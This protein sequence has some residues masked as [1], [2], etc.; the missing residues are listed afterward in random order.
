MQQ[1]VQTV[2]GVEKDSDCA[3][4]SEEIGGTLE[5]EQFITASNLDKQSSSFEE[6]SLWSETFEIELQVWDFELSDDTHIQSAFG[7]DP[8]N[9]RKYH[10][11]ENQDELET[12]LEKYYENFAAHRISPI[13]PMV[14]HPIHTDFEGHWWEGG[15]II[16]TD[17]AEG[18]F[19]MRIEDDQKDRDVFAVGKKL[20]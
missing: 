18:L 8:D 12:V 6:G 15:E 19:S 16:D 5:L 9:I 4:F 1:V 11:L 20:I 14:L 2:H 17:K 10:R 13:N 7:I 3:N